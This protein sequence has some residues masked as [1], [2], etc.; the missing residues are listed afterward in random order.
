MAKNSILREFDVK[1][2]VAVWQS[3]INGIRHYL[4]LFEVCLSKSILFSSFFQIELVYL[5]LQWLTFL[6]IAKFFSF[7]AHCVGVLVATMF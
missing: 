4:Y 5:Y 6:F 7:L 3:Y 2:R 1:S